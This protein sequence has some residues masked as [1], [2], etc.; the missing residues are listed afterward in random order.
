MNSR[1]RQPAT[2]VSRSPPAMSHGNDQNASRLDDVDQLEGESTQPTDACA[3]RMGR[4]QSR[5][6]RDTSNGVIEGGYEAVSQVGATSCV[7]PTN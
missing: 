3:T 5:V 4:P 7:E 6:R 2:P 1:L